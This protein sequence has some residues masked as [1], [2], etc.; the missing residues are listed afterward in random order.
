MILTM[1]PELSLGG[2]ATENGKLQLSNQALSLKASAQS[3]GY[4]LR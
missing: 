3:E 1:M 2:Q 4:Y